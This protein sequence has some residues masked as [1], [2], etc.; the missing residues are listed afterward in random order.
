MTHFDYDVIVIGSG[1]GAEAGAAVEAANRTERFPLMA[2]AF[3]VFNRRTF[4]GDFVS[5]SG[6]TG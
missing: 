3:A 1:A 6:S 2:D 5:S 4:T